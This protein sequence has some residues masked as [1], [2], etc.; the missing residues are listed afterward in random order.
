MLVF[1]VL[2]SAQQL[3][4]EPPKKFGTSVTGAYEGWYDN[5]DGT[6]TFL[7]G[8]YNRNSAQTLD[9]PIGP[10]NHIDPGGPDL[11]QPT[12][13]LPGRQYG[14]FTVTVPKDFAPT[15]RLTWTLVANGQSMTIPFTLKT[16]YNVSPFSDLAVKNT[17][18][19]L[20]LFDE[21]AAPIQGPVATIAKAMARTASV[22]SPLPLPVWASDDAK[23]TSGTNAP[24]ARPRPPVSLTWSKY[25]GPGEVTFDKA[26]PELQA[27]TGGA[28][29]EPYTG[30]ATATA[31][32]GAPGDYVL[33]LV[34]NDY[35]GNGGGGEVC[36]WTTA[37]VKVSVTP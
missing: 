16:D 18:P 29:N 9:I 17:P 10:N 22:S 15:Q 27:I 30:K 31:T 28:V 26:K 32:F 11:G 6:H 1:G 2:V 12:H 20:H 34:G 24:M 35:S 36:C 13:F 7:V 8:Y 14:M 25:R 37:M 3:P 21:K 23:Y 19:A 33:H 4:S 5:P